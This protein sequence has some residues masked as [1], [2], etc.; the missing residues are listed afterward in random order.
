MSYS[1]AELFGGSLA[2]G[3]A[4]FGA[5][6]LLNDL[7]M[8]Q[9]M[10]TSD[11]NQLSVRIPGPQDEQEYKKQQML[12]QQQNMLHHASAP[13]TGHESSQPG[14]VD[15]SEL[16]FSSPKTAE[17]PMGFDLNNLPPPQSGGGQGDSSGFLPYALA[18]TGLPLGFMGTK[19]LYDH[20]KGSQLD[21][22]IDRKKKEYEQALIQAKYGEETPLTDAF[23]EKVAE[24]LEKMALSPDQL[25]SIL[26]V[27]KE[28][29]LDHLPGR[30]MNSN[31][32]Q[33]VLQPGADA[34]KLVGGGS[35]LGL[36]AALISQHNRGKNKNNSQGYPSNVTLE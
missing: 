30:I 25:D 26:N 34:W 4:G 19:S 18:M 36:M 16:G 29:M 35:A 7:I 28:N 33:S 2:V 15:P 14:A 27:D 1:P 3:G 9:K 17:G 20:L 22:Q 12:A 10:Q 11:P 5:M 31:P 24:E 13:G 32:A 23:C 21:G 6:R 8:K